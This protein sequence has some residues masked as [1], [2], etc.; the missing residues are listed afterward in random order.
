MALKVAINGFGRIGRLAFRRMFNDAQFEIVAI[1]DLTDAESLAYL[2]EYDSAQGR[3]LHGEIAHEDGAITVQGTRI[4]IF[5]ERD[6]ENLPWKKLAVDVVVES[7]GFF[8]DRDKAN[9]HIVAGARKVIISAP[10]KGDLKTVVFNVNH[11]IL[12]ASDTIISGASCTTNCLAPVAKVLD[13]SF[14][15]VKGYMTTVHSFTND[16]STLDSPHPK[17]IHGRRG[18][19]ASANIVPTTTGAAVAVGK[20]LPSLN[21]KLDGIALRVP[22]VTGSIVDL[23]VELE[24]DASV[25]SI[26]AAMKAAS[27]ETLGYTD[28]P[29]VSSDTIGI[30]Y[31]SWFDS[32]MTSALEVD[33]KKLFKVLSWYDNEM[34]YVSQMVRTLAYFGNL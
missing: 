20:V 25:E 21:G 32:Q 9:K 22:T 11:D 27:S 13:D 17:G 34:S 26:N 5:A 7:T 12:D 6:P 19:T 1:N 10:A 4:P 31:G 14:G 2:L 29:L 8:T 23:V 3:F 30:T 16:Q 28:V 24:K 33:G 15:L 18:R